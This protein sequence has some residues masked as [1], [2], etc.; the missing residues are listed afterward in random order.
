MN[1]LGGR[2][3]SRA[4]DRDA[5]ALNQQIEKSSAGMGGDQ[6]AEQALRGAADEAAGRLDQERAQ[7][8]RLD[9]KTAESAR[10]VRESGERYEEATSRLS[11]LSAERQKTASRLSVL[12]EMQR[13]FEGYQ[14]S[15]KNVL[16]QARRANTSGVRGVVASL[17]RVPERLER[18]L[19]MALGGA[20][21]HIVVEREEDAKQ[22]IDY[23]RVNRLGRATFLPLSAVRGRTL[24]AAERRLLTMPGCLGV[25]S[26]LIEY[27]AAYRGVVENL[28][29]RTVV[30]ENLDAGIAIMRAGRHAFRLVTLSGDVMNPG[31]SMT[32]GSVQSRMTSLLTRGRELDGHR[33]QIARLDG[34]IASARELVSALEA[35]RAQL[36]RER[37]QLFETLHQQEIAVARE[38]AHLS[39]AQGELSAHL[40]RAKAAEDE[41]E[42]LAGQLQDVQAA[43]SHI[44]GREG[45]EERAGSLKREEISAM[46]KALAGD[47]AVTASLRQQVL[48]KSVRLAAQSKGLDALRAD[49]RRLTGERGN[50]SRL[51][52][53]SEA[54]KTACEARLAADRSSLEQAEGALGVARRSLETE[55]DGFHKAD[56]RAPTP[57]RR[58]S[59]W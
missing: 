5:R 59:G 35:E 58:W 7:K 22:M 32:G 44:D 55:R 34:E 27:D 29:G 16:L 25:A 24:D 51:L 54:E 6:T 40:K 33:S 9:E 4:P 17:I 45:G 31:G 10:Q 20:L 47:R 48:D 52:E 11:N 3:R 57:K 18:A 28:L 53:E 12:E 8:A 23:L 14:H 13:D 37:G 15:V 2:S 30:A 19:D 39:A 56:Q 26:E 46:Q 38:E 21:Q 41:R 43:L 1:R 49:L 50:L 42:R 36:K